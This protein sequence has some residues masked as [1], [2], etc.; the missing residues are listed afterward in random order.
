MKT[1]LVRES[2]PQGLSEARRGWTILAFISHL[3]RRGGVPS[4]AAAFI[5]IVSDELSVYRISLFSKRQ[6]TAEHLRIFNPAFSFPQ[7]NNYRTGNTSS[8]FLSAFAVGEDNLCP[9]FHP[10]ALYVMSDKRNCTKAGIYRLLCPLWRG[11]FCFPMT[12]LGSA[13]FSL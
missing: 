10:P 13:F 2:P 8:S 7:R 5:A 4:G 9:H 11:T 6:T 3:N 1:D 12:F